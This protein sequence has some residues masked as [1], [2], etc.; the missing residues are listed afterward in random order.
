MA[1]GSEARI[2]VAGV[3]AQEEN[4]TIERSTKES[5]ITQHVTRI[6]NR[7]AVAAADERIGPTGENGNKIKESKDPWN[8]LF[9]DDVL[10]L[11]LSLLSH[12][13]R[14]FLAYPLKSSHTT[15]AH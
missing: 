3:Y 12:F 13:H 14:A 11:S 2:A 15:H 6:G 10:L 8:K 5:N 1:L 7:L 9:L 4:Y